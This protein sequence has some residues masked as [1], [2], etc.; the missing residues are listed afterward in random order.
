M[1]LVLPC[2][3]TLNFTMPIGANI[4]IPGASMAVFYSLLFMVPNSLSYE[5][6]VILLV[7]GVMIALWTTT[8]IGD[9]LVAIGGV[10][11]L[12]MTGAIKVD[13]VYQTL[14]HELVWLLIA[15]F[16]IA[17][18]LRQSGLTERLI[19]SI[20][21]RQMGLRT[22]FHTLAFCI[23]C[24]ALFIP[25]TSGRA[26]LL[27]PVFLALVST[28]DDA[29]IRKALALLF[30]TVILL[31]AGGSLIGAGAHLIAAD[32]IYK[33][34]GD[35]VTYLGWFMTA[36]PLA[37]A[38]VV[39]ATE[40]ILHV[41]IAKEHRNT[42]IAP[43]ITKPEA[44][45]GQVWMALVAL[46]TVI[47]WATTQW[48]MLGLGGVAILGLI[49]ATLPGLSPI[50]FKAALKSVEWELLIFMA[51]TLLVGD[52]ILESDADEWFAK[53]IMPAF[54]VLG[55][56]SFALT[57]VAVA[58]VA[59]A[60]HL[61]ITSRTARATVLIPIIVIPLTG[62]GLDATTLILVVV[63]GT[64]FCQ[65][66]MVSAKPVALFGKAEGEYYDAKDLAQLSLHFA[67]VM[68]AVLSFFALIVWPFFGLAGE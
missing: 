56:K 25:S 64:G 49:A 54:A 55:A 57:I 45:E 1:T 16:G 67:P 5:A 26:A 8:K 61:V 40:V 42:I 23:T 32:F 48:H 51:L 29:A 41:V 52:A 27:L 28:I 33:I 30:P 60:S 7:L 17:S 36:M 19:G 21:N 10:M 59:A 15:S 3:P 35:S 63:M 12:A 46:F 53:Q 24:T 2:K 20:L 22:L 31:S 6:R 9:G 44:Q 18:A 39:L 14:G 4:L 37:L 11:V 38:T 43:A 65:T 58:V 68:I 47:G 13:M 34:T 66:M 62:L 50:S